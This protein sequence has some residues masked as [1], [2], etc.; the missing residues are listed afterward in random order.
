[1][2]L[3]AAI[4]S[5]SSDITL[6]VESVA[7]RMVYLVRENGILGSPASGSAQSGPAAAS[8]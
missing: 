1:M 3:T 8:L 5:S 6:I 7:L 4:L 2:R